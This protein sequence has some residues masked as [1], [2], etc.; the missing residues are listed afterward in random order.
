MT[1]SSVV[2]G[3]EDVEYIDDFVETSGDWELWEV[4]A[5]VDRSV[6]ITKSAYQQPRNQLTKIPVSLGC[7]FQSTSEGAWFEKCLWHL[8]TF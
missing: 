8:C 5:A 2:D 3:K 1:S 7:Y 4:I 6:E